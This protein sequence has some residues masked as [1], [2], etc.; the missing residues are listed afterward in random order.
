MVIG[1]GGAIGHRKT[2]NGKLKP[3][4]YGEGCPYCPSCFS[5]PFEDCMYEQG[6]F[7]SKQ[8][9]EIAQQIFTR[10]ESVKTLLD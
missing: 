2:L 4:L 9:K 1:Q 5:C 7:V 10:E 8:L 6:S 3:L